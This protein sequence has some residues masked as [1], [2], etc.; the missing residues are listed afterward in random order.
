MSRI[1]VMLRIHS[2]QNY[3]DQE[4]DVIELV[5]EGTLE[6]RNDV[7][8][9]SYEESDLTG[10][11][12]VTTIFKVSKR[13]ATVRR[14]GKL[15]SVMIFREGIR[16]ESLYQS[17]VGTFMVCVTA[18]KIACDMS[19]SGGTIDITYTI[20]IEHT[21]IGKVEYHLEITPRV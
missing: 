3:E 15:T 8:E 18:Q 2:T 16:H 11:E 4:P 21:A 7:W 1:P 9:V 10:L 5:T 13:G 14:T 12:G 17:E 20:E 19:E 6:H